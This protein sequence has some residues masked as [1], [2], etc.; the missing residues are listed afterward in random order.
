MEKLMFL[1]TP[2]EQCPLVVLTLN[3]HTHTKDLVIP[4]FEASATPDVRINSRNWRQSMLEGMTRETDRQHK[5]VVAAVSEIC[6]DLEKRCE[7]V[8]QPLRREE[9]RSERLRAALK[10]M[11]QRCAELEKE[12]ESKVQGIQDIE[13]DKMRTENKLDIAIA[14]TNDCIDR[15][16]VLEQALENARAE[17]IRIKQDSEKISNEREATHHEEVEWLRESADRASLEHMA[18]LNERQDKIDELEE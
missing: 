18:L 12:V 5:F 9:E 2:L 15:I 11:Q 3:N 13:Q 1:S 6:R 4:M 17:T 14:K 16:R 10:E 7:T 8:E